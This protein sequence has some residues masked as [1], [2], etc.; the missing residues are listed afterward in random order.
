M[1]DNFSLT[2]YF[3]N[4]YLKEAISR[5]NSTY[6]TPTTGIKKST[7]EYVTD[8]K[9]SNAQL[10]TKAMR[11]PNFT[12]YDKDGE[13]PYLNE[14]SIKEAFAFM[15]NQGANLAKQLGM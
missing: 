2:K 3:K 11:N 9:K 1:A 13:Q 5:N 6:V 15:S 8:A 14:K 12:A 7:A 4:Q 10:T